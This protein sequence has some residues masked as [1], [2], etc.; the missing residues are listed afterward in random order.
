MV[1]VEPYGSAPVINLKG[2]N[3]NKV[4]IIHSH[5]RGL[6]NCMQNNSKGIVVPGFSFACFTKPIY[7]GISSC[8]MAKLNKETDKT[9]VKF[10]CTYTGTDWYYLSFPYRCAY[11]GW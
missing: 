8:T 7:P 11:A 9:S 3:Y 10:K 1:V 4:K 5:W 6:E 2:P